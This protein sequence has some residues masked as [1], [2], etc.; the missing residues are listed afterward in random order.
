[1]RCN[2]QPESQRGT[3]WGSGA[4]KGRGV[5]GWEALAEMSADPREIVAQL[6]QGW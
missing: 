1:M 3:A 6:L 2:N 5:G 4:M